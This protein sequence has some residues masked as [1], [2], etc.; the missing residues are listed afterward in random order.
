MELIWNN[1]DCTTCILGIHITAAPGDAPPFVCQAMVVEQD[2]HLLLGAQTVLP[3]PGKPAW[4]LAN[5]L[6]REPVHALGAVVTTGHKPLRLLAIVHDI[7]HSP[8]CLP[9]HIRQA[10]RHILQITAH[11]Q[12]DTLAAPLLGTVHGHLSPSQSIG[13]FREALVE[14]PPI[15]LS[16]IWLILPPETGCE[17]LQQLVIQNKSN[18]N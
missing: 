11:K 3:D 10:W 15:H 5:T 6:E 2:T 16:R 17:C 4:Y 9:E 7:E 8:T 13:L 14:D 1:T 12:I 18:S